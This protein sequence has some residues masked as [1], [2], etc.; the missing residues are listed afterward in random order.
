MN[1]AKRAIRVMIC[2]AKLIA[3]GIR[4]ECEGLFAA[5]EHLFKQAVAQIK[6]LLPDID[7][8]ALFQQA[9]THFKDS[10]TKTWNWAQEH[11]WQ[12]GFIVLGIVTIVVAPVVA[13]KVLAAFGFTA[14]GPAAGTAAAAMQSLISPVAAGS[15]FAIMQSA[16]MG[17]YGLAIVVGSIQTAAAAGLGVAL[18]KFFR[19]KGGDDDDK[20]KVT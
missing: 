7:W 19:G 10:A 3:S 6:G 4:S 2:V 11:P 1:W 16:A 17:G 13:P 8:E 15:I 18:W 20:I 9:K 14:V 12:A 5:A